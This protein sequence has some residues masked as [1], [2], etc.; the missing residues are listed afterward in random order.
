M[1]YHDYHLKA[2]SVEEYGQTVTLHLSWDYEGASIE[3]SFIRFSDVS[4]YH[5]VHTQGAIITH[6]DEVELTDL[7]EEFSDRLPEWDRWYGVR[8]WKGD[9]QRTAA[10][11]Q[12]EGYRAWSIVSAIGFYGFV[13]ARSVGEVTP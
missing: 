13:I 9:A 12:T 5:F 1:R 8:G 3:D 11:L 4:L 6:L 10:H 2:Y 7:L